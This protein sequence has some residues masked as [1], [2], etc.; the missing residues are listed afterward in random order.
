[1]NEITTLIWLTHPAALNDAI[2]AYQDGTPINDAADEVLAALYTDDT[3][4]HYTDE[5][6]LAAITLAIQEN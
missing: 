3:F 1:M 4:N 6:L 5:Q 2:T